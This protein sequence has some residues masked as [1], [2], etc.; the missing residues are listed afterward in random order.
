MASDLLKTL[1][2]IEESRR[3]QIETARELGH[4]VKD[5]ASFLELATIM[6]QPLNKFPI[7]D[8]N[9]P[10][11]YPTVPDW[12]RPAEWPDCYS[13]LRN[14]EPYNNYYPMC[15]LL[16]KN[17]ADTIDIPVKTSTNTT[18]Y[19]WHECGLEALQLSDGTYYT[20]GA[21]ASSTTKQATHTWDQTKDIVDSEGNTYRWIIGYLKKTYSG[22]TSSYLNRPMLNFAMFPAIE[23]LLGDITFGTD[24]YYTS[25][26]LNYSSSSNGGTLSN[27]LV[28]FE[29][30][31]ECNLV[32]ATYA[33]AQCKGVNTLYLFQ[34]CKKLECLDFGPG[35]IFHFHM[36]SNYG[37]YWFDGATKLNKLD[38][39]KVKIVRT[40][41]YNTNRVSVYPQAFIEFKPPM[42][43]NN[44][45]L[46]F[47]I[48]G[49][50]QWYL[51]NYYKKF[52][53]QLKEDGYTVSATYP[54]TDISNLRGKRPNVE[55]D[56][57]TSGVVYQHEFQKTVVNATFTPSVNHTSY[58]LLHLDLSNATLT[59]PVTTNNTPI[60]Y[61]S[62]GSYVSK[63]YPVPSGLN[64]SYITNF[65]Y[66]PNLVSIVWPVGLKHRVNLLGTSV[67]K[68]VVLDLFEH[69]ANFAGAT[70]YY[71]YIFI[72]EKIYNELTEEE[73]AIATNKGWE[74]YDALYKII[75]D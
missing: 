40:G 69:C 13:I 22:T 14:A 48:G 17:A 18:T 12:I 39:S 58:N 73:L 51:A 37:C 32:N 52:I 21:Y 43:P 49:S 1:R 7:Q 3:L 27:N 72:P 64:S 53:E 63:T 70:V 34:G 61:V 71:P 8:Y 60:S 42:T 56:N 16:F 65:E 2:K 33:N 29:V 30:L 15:I 75:Q 44:W 54:Y 55:L 4:D 68:E 28:H 31:P 46:S 25:N 10:D 41:T 35:F 36:T 38:L 11:E 67:T 20:L 9:I 26:I 5:N 45:N 50:S 47:N 59:G 62:G 74:V 24:E 6:Q 57:D 23:V 66:F 19:Y